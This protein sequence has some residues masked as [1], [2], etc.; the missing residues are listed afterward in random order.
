M[1]SSYPSHWAHRCGWDSEREPATRP[2]PDRPKSPAAPWWWARIHYWSNART[3]RPAPAC[4]S[5]PDRTPQSPRDPAGH[6]RTDRT[7]TEENTHMET[8]FFTI[9]PK[10][11]ETRAHLKERAGV[12]LVQIDVDQ[13]QQ[14]FHLVVAHLPILVLIRTSQIASNPSVWS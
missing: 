10:Y 4:A 3:Q 2:R 8:L 6:H 11:P 7:S 12:L 9:L 14:V 5:V 13:L 1:M